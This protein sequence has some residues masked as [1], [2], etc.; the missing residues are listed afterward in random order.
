MRIDMPD[1]YDTQYVLNPV[2]LI[3]IQIP[4]LVR[5]YSWGGVSQNCVPRS[6][7]VHRFLKNYFGVTS[8]KLETRA[9]GARRKNDRQPSPTIVP[10]KSQASD[11]QWLRISQHS[12]Y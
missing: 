4:A 1:A 2:D 10:I 7:V 12:M 6:I 3:S 11:M 9:R 5:Y 8:C